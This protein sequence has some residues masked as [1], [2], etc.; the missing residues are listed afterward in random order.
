MK[1]KIVI[2]LLAGLGIIGYPLYAFLHKMLDWDHR[3]SESIV[4]SALCG[5]VTLAVL[6]CGVWWVFCHLHVTWG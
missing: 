3:T 5:L 2:A 6:C 4:V 1:E